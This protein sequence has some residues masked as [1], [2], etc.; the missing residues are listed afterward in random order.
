MLHRST[1]ALKAT[2]THCS[3]SLFRQSVTTSA[4]LFTDTKFGQ[5]LYCSSPV[6]FEAPVHN[7]FTR[8]TVCSGVFG[9]APLQLLPEGFG[10]PPVPYLLV[11]AVGVV[12]VAA[13][14]ARRRPAVTDRH[15][16]AAVP[17]ILTGAA[18][19]VLFVLEAVPP[20]VRPLFGTPAVYVTVTMLAGAVWLVGMTRVADTALLL[21]L[22]GLVPAVGTVAWVVAYGTSLGNVAPTLPAAGVIGGTAAGVVVVRSA[23]LVGV[24]FVSND[25]EPTRAVTL[26]L[27]A[28]GIDGVTTAV[29]T[30]LLGFGERTPLSAAVLEFAASLPTADL[31]G[32]G[33]LFVLV[34][35]AVASLAVAAIAPTVRES[36][37][38]GYG[39]L[40]LVAAVGLGPG[41]HNALLF[42]VA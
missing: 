15:A 8:A 24:D 38:E 5:A 35:L 37:S 27:A 23:R 17:W 21:G 33:W 12:A 28:H 10:L 4:V 30:D 34:K 14:F 26:A 19:H 9:T 1:L 7:T 2:E 40:T 22:V 25:G 39:L 31:L 18:A 42:T 11:L 29:G 20:V 3:S 6:F 41:L 16:L 13:G 36:P 32:A